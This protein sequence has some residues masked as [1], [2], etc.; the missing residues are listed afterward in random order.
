MSFQHIIVVM[1]SIYALFT[2]YPFYFIVFLTLYN[3]YQI[4]K[5]IQK[6]TLTHLRSKTELMQLIKYIKFA[7]P[8]SK[9]VVV[10]FDE[11]HKNQYTKCLYI[12]HWIFDSVVNCKLYY[13]VHNHKYIV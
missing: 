12:Q 1:L 9:I 8:E 5:K 4:W 11:I 7:Y 3:K 2:D 10:Q 13:N 6:Y